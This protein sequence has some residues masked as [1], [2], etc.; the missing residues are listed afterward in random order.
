MRAE[1]KDYKGKYKGRTKGKVR[2]NK[3]LKVYLLVGIYVYELNYF[4]DFKTK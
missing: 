1:A 2:K 4:H 3:K